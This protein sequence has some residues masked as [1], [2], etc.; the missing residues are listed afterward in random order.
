MQNY[1][2]NFETATGTSSVETNVINAD[3]KVHSLALDGNHVLASGLICTK[4]IGISN[5]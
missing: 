3:V 1:S 4:E 5:S 2:S